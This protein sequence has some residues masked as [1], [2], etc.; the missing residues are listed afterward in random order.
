MF[1]ALSC[2]VGARKLC[3]LWQKESRRMKVINQ[4]VIVISACDNLALLLALGIVLRKELLYKFYKLCS[5]YLFCFALTT[6]RKVFLCKNEK[7]WQNL[8]PIKP[9][10]ICYQGTLTLPTQLTFFSYKIEKP[11]R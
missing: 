9:V 2:P 3:L 11:S 7:S 10:G 5:L 6:P 1:S 8:C 4:L